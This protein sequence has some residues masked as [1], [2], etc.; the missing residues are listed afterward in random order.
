MIQKMFNSIDL[1]QKGMDAAWLRNEVITNNI[2]NAET[3]NFKSSSVAFETMFKKALEDQVQAQSAPGD[4]IAQQDAF[5]NNISS[6]YEN[7]RTRDKH[8]V[9]SPNEDIVDTANGL[10][11]EFSNNR[12]RGSHF[13]FDGS[14]QAQRL[15]DISPVVSQNDDLTMRMDGNNVD[16]EAENVALARNTIYYYTLTEQMNSEFSR[17]GMAIREGK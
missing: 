13:N 2:A 1:L 9:F 10:N 6:Q 12:T 16:V 7:K 15:S 14:T 17:L 3:P 5:S 11:E 8:I 4:E